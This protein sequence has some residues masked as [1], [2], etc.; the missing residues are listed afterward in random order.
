M[1]DEE[2][3]EEARRFYQQLYS[4]EA[5]DQEMQQDLLEQLE[6]QLPDKMRTSSEGPVMKVELNA[7]PECT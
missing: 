6:T 2:I 7:A 5:C 1:T 3:L 4:Y